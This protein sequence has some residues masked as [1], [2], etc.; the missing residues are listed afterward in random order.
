MRDEWHASGLPNRTLFDREGLS[1]PSF[2]AWKKKTDSKI[3]VLHMDE[4]RS[5]KRYVPAVS[6]SINNTNADPSATITSPIYV[7]TDIVEEVSGHEVTITSSTTAEVGSDLGEVAGSLQSTMT[8]G[9][10]WRY[11]ESRETVTQRTVPSHP[12]AACTSETIYDVFIFTE[13]N[14]SYVA[15]E[16]GWTNSYGQGTGTF[17]DEFYVGISYAH[18]TNSVQREARLN[19]DNSLIYYPE[20][21]AVGG[22]GP[23]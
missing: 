7:K 17:T 11:T 2:Y 1:Q 21:A 9:Q 14:Y 22:N 15:F 4:V 13:I 10:E 6:A 18:E 19:S 5:Y 8:Q 3:L 23:L 12:V 20:I 16:D